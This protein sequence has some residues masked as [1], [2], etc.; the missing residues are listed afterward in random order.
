MDDV[1]EEEKWRRFRVIEKLQ[2]GIAAEH[3]EKLMNKTV[4]V[5]FE[6]KKHRR[7][8]GRTENMDLVFADSEEDL[9]GKLLPITINWT[10]PWTMG[11]EWGE[12][13]L[14]GSW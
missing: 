10:S 9:T 11:G 13:L 5:L 8:L 7:W 12:R 14:V 2:E 3:H 1:S 6:E 4:S